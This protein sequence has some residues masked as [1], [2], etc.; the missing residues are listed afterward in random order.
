MNLS[1]PPSRK[2]G[3]KQLHAAI[4]SGINTILIYWN[5]RFKVTSECVSKIYLSV[6]EMETV[7]LKYIKIT[8]KENVDWLVKT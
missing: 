3:L 1:I 7:F 5:A 6:Q 2:E 8:N 4:T